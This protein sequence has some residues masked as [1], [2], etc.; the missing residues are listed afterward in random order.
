MAEEAEQMAEELRQADVVLT[1]YA[2]LAEEV[3]FT[4]EERS[5]RHAKRYKFSEGPLMRVW[6]VPLHPLVCLGESRL[7][8]SD[9]AY[10]FLPFPPGLSFCLSI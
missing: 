1:T 10:T 6:W 7:S 9:Q 5:L 3:N 2:V 4:N 8:K